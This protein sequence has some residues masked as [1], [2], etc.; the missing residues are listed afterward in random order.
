MTRAQHSMGLEE[1]AVAVLLGA[2]S[3]AGIFLV[4]ACGWVCISALCAKPPP[5]RFA[6]VQSYG[7][8]S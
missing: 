7:A 5:T 4:C 3:G 1:H 6:R 2:L 8:V